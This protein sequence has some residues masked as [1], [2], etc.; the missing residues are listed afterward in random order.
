MATP[1]NSIRVEN[2][3]LQALLVV[4]VSVLSFFLI[5][6][7]DRFEAQLDDL[8]DENKARDAKLAELV[9]NV[10]KRLTILESK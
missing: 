6:M 2:R 4:T 9:L 1:E 10:E 7:F 3:I 8:E 5:N